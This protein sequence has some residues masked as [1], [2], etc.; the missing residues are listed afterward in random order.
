MTAAHKLTVEDLTLGYGDRV[1]ITSLDR[2]LTELE[3]W[4]ER[5]KV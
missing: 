4:E 3:K 1:V 5:Q 2:M